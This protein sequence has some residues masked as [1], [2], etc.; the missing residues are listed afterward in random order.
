MIIENTFMVPSGK[1]IDW[2]MAAFSSE[3]DGIDQ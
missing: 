1:K 3:Q 2:K